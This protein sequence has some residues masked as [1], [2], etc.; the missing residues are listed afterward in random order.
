MFGD[1]VDKSVRLTFLGHA[2]ALYSAEI[3]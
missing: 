2:V 1:D 3:D